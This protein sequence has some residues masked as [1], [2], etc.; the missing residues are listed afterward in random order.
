MS[1]TIISA[2]DA[3]DILEAISLYYFPDGSTKFT[4]L[5]VRLVRRDKE[6]NELLKTITPDK[7]VIQFTGEQTPMS[8][9]P[10]T[11]SMMLDEEET[12]G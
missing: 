10:L 1:A 12:D 7:F 5:H 2:P 6:G 4:E 11:M 9:E 8:P 3:E